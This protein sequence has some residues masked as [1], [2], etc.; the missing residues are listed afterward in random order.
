GEKGGGPCGRAGP[1]RRAARSLATACA[2]TPLNPLGPLKPLLNLLG[3]CMGPAR[4]QPI[5]ICK[6]V[7]PWLLLSPVA[8]HTPAVTVMPPAV[9]VP[10]MVVPV[11]V[12]AVGIVA[13]VGIPMVIVVGRS[14]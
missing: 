12:I 6:R 9:A 13:G 10:M 2:Q 14:G 4:G 3:L 8:P 1:P 11:A 7:R 5:I